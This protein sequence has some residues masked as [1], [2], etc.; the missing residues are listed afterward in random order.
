M[1]Q[2]LRDKMGRL[3]GKIKTTGN[4]KQEIRDNMGR[5][6]GTYDEKSNETRD[7]MGRLVGKGNQLSSLL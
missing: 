1:D 5:L 6:K 3:I 4:G 7:N 2:E